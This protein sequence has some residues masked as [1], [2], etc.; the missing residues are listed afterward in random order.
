[1]IGNWRLSH[2]LDSPGGVPSAKLGR[3]IRASSR[4]SQDK[5]ADLNNVL[6]RLFGH[7]IVK[8][9]AMEAFE[10]EKFKNTTRLCCGLACAG[11]AQAVSSLGSWRVPAHH[12]RRDSCFTSA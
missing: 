12:H 8:A 2:G 1:M 5:M 6:R 7:R 4:S 9:F 10:I 11:Y 3:Y